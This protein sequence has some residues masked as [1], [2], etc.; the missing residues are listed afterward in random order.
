MIRGQ[1]KKMNREIEILPKLIVLFLTLFSACCVIA[2]L[3]FPYVKKYE[4]MS[5][6]GTWIAFIITII[7]AV[8]LFRAS[9]RV[10]LKVLKC[11]VVCTVFLVSMCQLLVVFNMQLIPR[12]DLSH[13]YDQV[14][15]MLENNIDVLT[16]KKYFGMYPN[17]IPLA[18]LIYWLFR[19]SNSIGFTNYRIVGGIFNLL[20]I[21][22]S[23]FFLYLVA[24]AKF[25]QKRALFFIG[26]VAIN[27]L[28]VAYASYYYTDT[29]SLPF[30]ASASFFLLTETKDNTQT[31]QSTLRYVLGGFLLA[32]AVKIRV[33]SI[34]LGFAILTYIII[35]RQLL[36]KK[37]CLLA[38]LVGF[39]LFQ[40]IFSFIYQKHVTFDTHET[41]MPA[42]HFLMMASRGDGTFDAED[43]EFTLSFPTHDEKVEN[44]LRV[45]KERIKDNGILG[46]IALVIFKEAQVW[47]MGPHAFT[48]YTEFVTE[49][50]LVYN[51]IRGNK[52]G[53]FYNY[54]QGY[55]AAFFLMMLFSTVLSRREYSAFQQIIAIY[56]IGSIVFYMFWEANPRHVFCIMILSSFLLIPPNESMQFFK[57]HKG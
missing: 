20:C 16:D 13:I 28:F 42:T 29:I 15:V 56:L 25:G 31:I 39:A 5:I 43:V 45:Y 14:M 18:I 3:I 51:L 2:S 8:C 24:K 54:T 23:W 10:S 9:Q 37:K 6:E 48:S 22:T 1:V 34:F 12:V 33:T 36:K 35:K 26:I 40:L 52:S 50:T 11:M 4:S 49:K 32:I 41:A 57:L 17:N 30:L 21:W 19:L 27:P 55:N 44:N 47:G 7:Y 38:A 53:W 46:N